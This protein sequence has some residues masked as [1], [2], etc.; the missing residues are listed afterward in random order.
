[1]TDLGS[2]F[3]LALPETDRIPFRN[4]A[5]IRP[6]L[7]TERQL[8][9]IESF[10]RN[11]ASPRLLTLIARTPHWLVNA[12]V[13]HAL[14]G[15]ECTPEPIRRDL[16]LAVSL[17][18][19]MREMDR[20]PEAEREERSEAIR[21]TYQQLSA[22]L[23]PVVKQM[24]KQLS[25]SVNAT[26]TT[27]DM[28][29]LPTTEPDWEVL[30][31]PP[32]GR[33]RTGPVFRAPVPDR[34][35]SAESTL[36]QEDLE[37]FLM[38]DSAEVRAA[39]L[40]NPA[41]TEEVVLHFM[42]MGA[43]PELFDEVYQEARWYFKDPVREAFL[44]APACP[45]SIARKMSLSRDLVQM[46][47]RR[48][49]SRRQLHRI[50]SLFTQLE[51]SEYQ[52]LTYWAKRRAPSMLRV[53]KV[54][55]DRL[56]RRRTS[57]ASGLGGSPTDGRWVS[58]EE[59]VFMANQASQPEQIAAA[60][61]DSDPQVFQVALENPGLTPRE[62]VS[63]IPHLDSIRAERVAQS[64]TWSGYPSVREA[65]LHN[66]HLP[67]AAALSI[68]RGLGGAP[69]VMLDVLRDQRIPHPSVKQ[70]A[71]GMLRQAYLEMSAP[72]R[73]VALR[74]SGGELLRHLPGEVLKDEETLRMLISDRQ[75]DPAILLRL[76]RNKLTPRPILEQIAGHPVLMAHPAVMTELLLNPKTPRQ[77]S[78]RIW[79]LLSEAE[80]R[81]L[82]RS[83]HLP[84]SLRVL[85]QFG[86][87]T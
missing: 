36:L 45:D 48:G 21:T 39:A 20:A 26:G 59:R 55:F 11:L 70:E 69:R 42:A 8:E 6:Q 63:V 4:L 2:S 75:L 57:Q 23:K 28:P 68:L 76:A 29:P 19:L 78:T 61:R 5:L 44:E 79:G 60:L 71:L 24:A 31:R 16:E 43:R 86:S 37:R 46:L 51:A 18:D 47:E 3:L 85:T 49:R 62:L 9:L 10:A 33:T 77:A 13:L 72:Q 53:I 27:L 52:F 64:R 32:Q 82:L 80:Q 12:S 41:L 14:A 15:N 1:M 7:P 17:M 30:T 83:P 66:V 56:Q 34:V 65:L 84:T 74:S 73:I 67:E 54:F 25:R 38:D 22:E 40:R 58:L 81:Q 35:A 50:V 87:G